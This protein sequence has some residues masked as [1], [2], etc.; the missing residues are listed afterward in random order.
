MIKCYSDMTRKYYDN[1]EEAQKAEQEMLDASKKKEDEKSLALDNLR[2]GYDAIE[3][4]RT[5]TNTAI[6]T[7]SKSRQDF[8]KQLT[9]FHKKYGYIPSEYR[10]Y[11][12]LTMFF[13][14]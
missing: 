1:F 7:Y 13:N 5:E 3:R 11:N 14:W 9:E 4:L 8:S 10:N 12:P 2:A 6:E